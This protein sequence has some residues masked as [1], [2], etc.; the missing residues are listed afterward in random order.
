MKNKAA[1]HEFRIKRVYDEP[2]PADG[3]RFLVDRLWPRGVRKEAL[4]ASGWFKEAAP[5]QA[6]RKWFDHQPAKWPEFR[7]RYCSEL[8]K[9][10][11]AWVPLLEAAQ[12]DTVTLLFA[13][14]DVEKN[15]AVVLKEFLTKKIQGPGFLPACPM[16]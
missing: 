14:R 7:R 4:R 5:S 10:P 13:A 1:G 15:Q 12:K 11:A 6:L 8:E 3:L 9:N 2:A 16:V